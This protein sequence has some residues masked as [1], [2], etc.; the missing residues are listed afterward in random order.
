MRLCTY[1]H[2]MPCKASHARFHSPPADG[3][4]HFNA[5]T[6]AQLALFMLAFRNDFLIDLDRNATLRITIFGEQFGH[7]YRFDQFVLRA[8]QGNCEHVA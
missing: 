1:K 7:A 3:V 5:I 4:D 2:V 6:I 8:I